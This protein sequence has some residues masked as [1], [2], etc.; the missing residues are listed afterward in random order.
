MVRIRTRDFGHTDVEQVWND[1]LV[2]TESIGYACHEDGLWS[3][4]VDGVDDVIA[5]LWM[6]L[7]SE[8]LGGVQVKVE[9]IEVRRLGS[10]RR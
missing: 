4:L 3:D 6:R 5:K 10:M 8:T 7:V 9:L 1:H 2:E